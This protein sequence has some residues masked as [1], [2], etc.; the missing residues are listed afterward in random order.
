MLSQALIAIADQAKKHGAADA[1]HLIRRFVVRLKQSVFEGQG[2]PE[3]TLQK[4]VDAVQAGF[5]SQDYNSAQRAVAALLAAVIRQD[6]DPAHT[7]AVALA[8]AFMNMALSSAAGASTQIGAAVLRKMHERFE[9]DR[10]GF[11][12][13]GWSSAKETFDYL[14]ETI[15]FCAAEIEQ[16]RDPF[17]SVAEGPAPE[18][19]PEDDPEEAKDG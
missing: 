5:A 3:D 4:M 1:Y 11:E 19:D 10:A 16:G 15:E 14:A 2:V 8:P 7:I 9:E 6:A 17:D 18:D 13:N 12:E